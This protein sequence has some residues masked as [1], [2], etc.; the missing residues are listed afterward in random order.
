MPLYE[1][2]F[3]ARKDVS[4]QQVESLTGTFKSIIEDNGGKVTKT[5]Y[6][7]LKTL[8]YKV[9]KNRK[10]HYT[11]LNIDAPSAALSEMERQM[12]LHEDILRHLS[13]RVDKLEEGPS[14]MLRSKI[15]PRGRDERNNRPPRD[16][17]TVAKDGAGKDKDKDKNKDIS[18][19]ENT[20]NAAAEENTK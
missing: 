15:P 16:R 2:V 5:E 1:H 7:G 6:W 19:K 9:R 4:A 18:D 13:L 11:L 20:S 10:G 8:A 3:I 14:A 17:G 12:S